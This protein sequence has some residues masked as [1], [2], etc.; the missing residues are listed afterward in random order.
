MDCLW[1]GATYLA[2]RWSFL[3]LLVFLQGGKYSTADGR[4]TIFACNLFDVTPE[5]VGKVDAVWD[6]GSF[7]ALSFDTRPR[8]AELLKRLVGNSFR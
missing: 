4:I 3:F 1:S 8:Y 6:R 5:M 7:V 2:S